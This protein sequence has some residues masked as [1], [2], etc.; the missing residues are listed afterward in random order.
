M[1]PLNMS[2]TIAQRKEIDK[3]NRE[4]LK[5]KRSI[6]DINMKIGKL[7]QNKIDIINIK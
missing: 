4:I 3:V 7:E 2:G 5:L 1:K 6:F